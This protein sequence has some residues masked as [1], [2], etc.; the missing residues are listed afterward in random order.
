MPCGVSAKELI[1]VGEAEQVSWIS[2]L[3]NMDPGEGNGKEERKSKTPNHKSSGLNAQKAKGE[4]LRS[5]VKKGLMAI[6]EC[7]KPMTKFN[8]PLSC[9]FAF[10]VPSQNPPGF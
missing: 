9:T 8:V 5:K 1:N 3:L 7:L 10:N 2:Y 4:V 6:H